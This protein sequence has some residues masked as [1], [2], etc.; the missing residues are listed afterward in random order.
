M[1]FCWSISFS[2]IVNRFFFCNDDFLISESSVSFCCLTYWSVRHEE[3]SL[4]NCYG[5]YVCYSS[6]SSPKLSFFGPLPLELPSSISA[7]V[8]SSSSASSSYKELKAKKA[9]TVW[10]ISHWVILL[11]LFL[12]SLDLLSTD[13]SRVLRIMITRAIACRDTSTNGD[14]G[15][16]QRETWHELLKALNAATAALLLIFHF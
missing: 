10:L 8:S 2:D 4:K 1:F 12:S 13:I 11:A 3:N 7:F 9:Y 16:E 6:S 5:S 14:K 15:L